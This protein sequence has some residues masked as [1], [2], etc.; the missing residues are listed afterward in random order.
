M[1]QRDSN[2]KNDSDDLYNHI[3][4]LQKAVLR[5]NQQIAHLQSENAGLQRRVD[6]LQSQMVTVMDNL[7]TLKANES[8]QQGKD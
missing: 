2:G 8:K 3:V 1:S 7:L 4:E 5:Q 6:D